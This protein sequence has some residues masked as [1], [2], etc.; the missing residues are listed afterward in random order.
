MDLVKETP[1]TLRL[2]SKA[3]NCE[4]TFEKGLLFPLV[5]GTDVS[6][7][8]DLPER[9][10]ILFPYKVENETAS[11]L[12]FDL[13]EKKFPKTA[14]YFLE[15]KKRL[16]GR[17]N[18]KA[19]GPTWYGYI[20]LKNMT[21]QAVK[22]AC[23]PRLVDELCATYDQEGIH[24]LDNVD[25]G[26]VTL[27]PK[28]QEHNL[29]F[30]VGLINSRL[31][32]WYFPFVS[33]PFRGGWRSANKQF[34]SQLPI[35]PIDFSKAADKAAHDRMVALVEKMLE[36]HKRLA[37]A[38]GESGKPAIERLIAATDAEIDRLVYD[39]YGLTK[40]EIAIV[41]RSGGSAEK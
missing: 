1:L 6:R 38:K 30:L 12:A 26:G 24:F 40:E 37:A 11:L 23:V 4:W 17:E 3:Q 36:L 9:Q 8:R 28:H 19:K 18:G 41:E 10:Y 22:K 20:Y 7:Y 2:K 33:A 5:S 15:N 14:T 29:A 27:K 39:L 13:I 35:R 25:V 16:E 34:L 32:R 21:R 31:L